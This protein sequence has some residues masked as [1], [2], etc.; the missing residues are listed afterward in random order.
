MNI[1]QIHFSPGER[2]TSDGKQYYIIHIVSLETVI[3]KD[4]ETGQ[5]CHLNIKNLSLTP[6][7]QTQKDCKTLPEN[8]NI[9]LV[10]DKQWEEA[11]RRYNI[12]RPLLECSHRTALIVSEQAYQQGVSIMTI[13]RWIKAFESTGRISSLIDQRNGGKGKSRL[14]DEVEIIIQATIKDFFLTMQKRSVQKTCVE[15]ITRCRNAKLPLPSFNTVRN[16][17]GQITG[18]TKLKQR[19]SAKK[20]YEQFAPQIGKFPGAD[21]PLAVIQIDHTLVDIIL[22]DEVYRLPIGRPYITLAIDVF[23]RM[24]AGIYISFDSPSALSVGLCIVHAILPKDKWLAKFGLTTSWPLWGIMRKIHVDNAKEFRGEM[25]KRAC[26][27][28]GI[29]IE[30]RPVRRPQYGAHIESLL[31]TFLEEIHSLPGTTFSNP[32]KRGEYNSENNAAMTL[33]EF[34]EWLINYI[35][36]VYHQKIHTSLKT[37]PIKQ[38]EKGIFGTEDML[39]IGLPNIIVDEERLRLDFMPYVERTVQTYGVII[40][41]IYYYSDTL[42]RYINSTLPESLKRKRKFLFKRDP[43]DISV[44]YFYDPEIKQYYSVP[45]RDISHPP[46]SIWELR[47]I[48]NHL[49]KEGKTNIDEDLIF[50]TYKRMREVEEKAIRD[51]KTVRLAKQ[52]RALN[53]QS[54]SHLVKDIKPQVAE[55]DVESN[56]PNKTILPFT[57]IEELDLE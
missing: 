9:L 35:T 52:R 50:E 21:W 2:V 49:E 46:I 41:R 39:G 25:L 15:V 51:S 4:E 30:W 18:E 45:Y 38:Y 28:Y 31:G 26:Q 53:K 6:T 7:S 8:E 1:R 10:A 5:I 54:T 22:V 56:K 36:G 33:R 13:Y 11:N 27:E 19:E 37:S 48:N 47:K 34:E 42:R 12:I 16:R 57:D 17:I 43:R 20:A 3:C 32:Q 29:D 55:A 14:E 40:D 23:S 44:I 24:V